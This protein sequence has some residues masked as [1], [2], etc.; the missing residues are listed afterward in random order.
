MLPEVAPVGD[1][2]M[3]KFQRNLSRYGKVTHQ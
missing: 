1:R 2:Y 3:T